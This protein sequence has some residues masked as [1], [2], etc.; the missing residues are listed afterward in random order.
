MLAKDLCKLPTIRSH[1]RE[2]NIRCPSLRVLMPADFI[3]AA[4]E[5]ELAG[6]VIAKRKN[7]GYE[8]GRR[9]GASIRLIVHRS[10]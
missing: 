9:S 1:W 10:S 3:G 5:L 6:H 2:W 8:P 4:K 7:S